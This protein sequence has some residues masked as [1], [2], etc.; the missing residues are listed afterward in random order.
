MRRRHLAHDS[1]SSL[2]AAAIAALAAGTAMASDL[3]ARGTVFH[4]LDGDGVRDNAEPGIEGV[5]VSNGEDIVLTDERGAFAIEIDE[6]DDIVF[7]IKPRGYR[8][9]LDP[10]LNLP[11]FY[12]IHKPAGSPD[13]GFNYA[14]V[15][16]TGPLPES[17][18]FPLYEQAEGDSFRALLFGDPQPYT[19]QQL[20]YYG[21]EIIDEVHAADNHGADLVIV[22]GDLLG[23][24]LELYEPYNEANA[25]LGVPI[26]NIYGNHDVNF[27]S[28]TD[29]HGDETF[30]RVFGPTTYAFQHGP[31]HFVVLDN[32]RWDGFNGLR[33]DG[34]P[35]T[36]NY[37]GWLRDD[38]LGF[39]ENLVAT[40]PSDERI[41]LAMHIPLYDPGATKHQTT[42]YRRVMEILSGH[43]HT[44][45]FS[46]HTHRLWSQ[47]MGSEQGYTTELGLPHM[48]FNAGATSGS[49]WRGPIDADGLP[50]AIMTDGTPNGY[51]VASFDEADY[52][53][54]WKVAGE[55]FERQMHA[56]LPDVIAE[57]DAGGLPFTVNAYMAR[58]SEPVQWRLTT[59]RGDALTRWSPMAHAPRTPDPAYVDLF[60]RDRE[61]GLSPEGRSL[62]DPNPCSHLFRAA[63]PSGLAVG[64]YVLETR[65][66]DMWG[67]THEGTRPFRVRPDAEHLFAK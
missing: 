23:D 54:L 52:S 17:I 24:Y 10:M 56:H 67:Q 13:D 3:V 27:M 47:S 19:E 57:S 1:V 11:R 62:R 31:V 41:V 45:S 55:P 33:D 53:L 21:R 6:D 25:R 32:V 39:L 12:H 38:Q 4:D 63:L 64:G 26:Y 29:K 8:T 42:Q 35:Q 20:A 30:E 66:T 58:A 46:A 37:Q 40:I 51:L 28:P 34:F 16:P 43:P 59:S 49:W 36:G 50:F 61:Q 44:V 7:V 2:F 60:T 14:G 15:A 22:L 48:H 9:A 5:K 18:D 65:F